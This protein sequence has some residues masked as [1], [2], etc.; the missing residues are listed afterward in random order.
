MIVNSWHFIN[1]E[2]SFFV[3]TFWYLTNLKF[4]L[5]EGLPAS[6]WEIKR[7]I[8][9]KQVLHSVVS[10]FLSAVGISPLYCSLFGLFRVRDRLWFSP[11]HIFHPDESTSEDV[12]FRLR[13]H[14][15]SFNCV[16]ALDMSSCPLFS[17][18]FVVVV[19]SVDGRYYYPGWYSGG[20]SRAFRYGVAKGSDSPVIDDFV[21]SYLFFQVS[22]SAYNIPHTTQCCTLGTSP[23]PWQLMG[24]LFDW[25]LLGSKLEYHL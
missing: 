21:M 4:P 17:H 3:L 9:F 12:F 5:V 15:S 18:N 11:N 8:G 14:T 22:I 1:C 6:H 19:F 2:S 10:G 23:Y 13:Y 24:Y 7:E 25:F 20:A 16:W